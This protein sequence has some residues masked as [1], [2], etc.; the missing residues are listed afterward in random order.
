MGRLTIFTSSKGGAGSSCCVS[1]IA[2]AAALCNQKVLCV[3]MN[4]DGRCL[5]LLLST[6][7][8]TVFDFFDVV[9]GKIQLMNAVVANSKLS[10]I[11]VLAASKFNDDL[12]LSDIELFF[13]TSV[14]NFDHVFVDCDRKT[15]KELSG[16]NCKA[17]FVVVTS[18]EAIA[19]KNVYS[20]TDSN[21][22]AK[23]D[24]YFILN[25]FEWKKMKRHT[26]D[27]IVNTCGVR[28]LGIVPKDKIVGKCFE[29]GEP[30]VTGRA[31]KAFMRIFARIDSC[32]INLPE[33]KKI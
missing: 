12:S 20:L 16:I 15:F 33:I 8:K 18:A 22:F 10:N 30:I 23:K 17:K 25:F 32:H 2:A 29:N 11:S 14:A 28:L 24:V 27:E 13:E 4:C 1:A 9:S 21:D 5:D 3:D 31:A 6:S 19:L 26:L 7:E